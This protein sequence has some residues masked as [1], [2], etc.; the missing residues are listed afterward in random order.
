MESFTMK[1]VLCNEHS[2]IEQEIVDLKDNMTSIN[3]KLNYIIVVTLLL[4][5]DKIWQLLMNF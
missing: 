3:N 2:K 4:F 1:P 5:G